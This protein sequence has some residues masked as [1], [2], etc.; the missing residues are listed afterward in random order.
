MGKSEGIK[1]IITIILA[2]IIL[3]LSISLNNTS[4]LLYSVISFLIIIGLNVITKKIVGCFLEAKVKTKFWEWYQYWFTKKSHFK[5]PIPMIWLP[6][7]LSFVTKGFFW[8]L[9]ALEFDLEPRKERV[10]RRHGLY[11][12]S[13]LTEWHTAWIAA[14]GIIVNLVLAIVGYITGFEAFA[15]LNI[16]FAAW[17]LLP[18]SSL[19]GS[20]IFFGSKALWFTFLVIVAIFLG[21]ALIIV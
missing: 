21:Y 5:K 6:I 9:A 15:R 19:D 11:R 2:I 3:S 7:V 20:K 17:S 14:A 12:F 18:L 8:W 4:I 10:S 16:Y 1:E 13:E